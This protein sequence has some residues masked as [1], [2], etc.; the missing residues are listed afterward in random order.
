MNILGIA[1]TTITAIVFQ[2]KG[3]PPAPDSKMGPGGPQPGETTPIDDQI[4]FLI[5]AGILIGAF[6]AY[7]RYKLRAT[8]VQ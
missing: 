2:D 5:I 6:Y 3:G 1:L 4:I 7:K 8:V